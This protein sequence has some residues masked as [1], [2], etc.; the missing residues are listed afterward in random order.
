MADEYRAACKLFV[1]IFLRRP[2]LIPI[3]VI[4]ICHVQFRICGLTGM[5][6]I[7][8]LYYWHDFA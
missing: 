7:I 3:A 6:L 8:T 5:F 4:N 2:Q 1:V